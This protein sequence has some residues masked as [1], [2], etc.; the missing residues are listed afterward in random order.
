VQHLHVSQSPSTCCPVGVKV[1]CCILCRL[2]MCVIHGSILE[3]CSLFLP[4][5]SGAGSMALLLWHRDDDEHA[6]RAVPRE[7]LRMLVTACTVLI[8]FLV[9]TTCMLCCLSPVLLRILA[10][11]SAVAFACLQVQWHWVRLNRWACFAAAAMCVACA[12][13]SCVNIDST[14]M[15]SK[16]AA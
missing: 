14:S 12:I 6:G 5:R 3:Q 13:H 1:Y 15:Q 11:A 4:L 7:A 9:Y 2:G 10:A 8:L 16:K